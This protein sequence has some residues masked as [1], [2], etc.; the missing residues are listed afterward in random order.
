METK[1]NIKHEEGQV[2]ERV[3]V[4]AD[5]NVV[6]TQ[7]KPFNRKRFLLHLAAVAAVVLAIVL[8]MS[9]FFKVENV[10]VSGTN[11]YDEWTVR[12][13]SGIADGEN[14][15]TLSKARVS[16]NIMAEL[17][18]VSSVRIGIELPGTV[19]IQITELE[20]VYAIQSTDESWWLI[21]SEGKVV[22]K[23]SAAAA[24]DYTRILGVLLA[25]PQVGADGTA[26]EEAAP[27]GEET[28]PVTVYNWE[29]LDAAVSILQY[30]E[31]AGMI[32]T[33]TTLDVSD[34][35]DIQMWYGTR[36]QILLGDNTNLYTKVKS[37]KGA[38]DQM[39]DYHSGELDASFTAW[40]T[41]V[42]YKPFP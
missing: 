40:P 13:A 7:G 18:Y 4:K 24:E 30:L 33:V 3:R 8:G 32:G 17:P 9:I 41:E 34:M 27:E 14:L 1:E 10:T 19:H 39:D 26:Y 20:V 29:R 5:V 42:A 22:E 31:D 11:K 12:Q 23:S 28:V 16:S 36:F 15:F 38:I 35:G 2:R 25:D 6:Y 21:N 37:V